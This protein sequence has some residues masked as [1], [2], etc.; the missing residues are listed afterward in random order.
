[1]AKVTLTLTLPS[2]VDVNKFFEAVNTQVKGRYNS[3]RYFAD[4]AI[5]EFKHRR[6]VVS[7]TTWK[8]FSVYEIDAQELEPAVISVM[9]EFKTFGN[10]DFDF[11]IGGLNLA[12]Q[13]FWKITSD[14]MFD[15]GHDCGF[16]ELDANLK[17]VYDVT[18]ARYAAEIYR[19]KLALREGTNNEQ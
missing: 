19:A 2:T 4:L 15:E 10:F 17:V 3:A 1:M 16:E 13:K 18:A 9:D 12:N 5:P 14:E 11:R 8:V 6:N 7:A